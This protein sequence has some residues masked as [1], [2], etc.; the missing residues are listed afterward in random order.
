MEKTATLH[1]ISA[2]TTLHA[3]LQVLLGLALFM[4]CIFQSVSIHMPIMV[5]MGDA[6]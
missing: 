5:G 4:S 1:D 3:V 6:S 2:L